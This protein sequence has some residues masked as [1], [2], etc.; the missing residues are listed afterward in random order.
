MPRLEHIGSQS[1]AGLA[2][3]RLQFRDGSDTDR[4]RQEV[5]NRLATISQPLPRDVVPQLHPVTAADPLLCYTLRA[6]RGNDGKSVYTPS[7]LRALQD[8][9]IEREFRRVPRVA[10]VRSAGGAVRR[11]E[12]QL[13]PDRLRR[14]GIT[15][16]QLQ[17]AIV[18]ANANTPGGTYVEQGRVALN[19]R[20]VGLFGGGTDPVL[21]VLG[22]QDPRQAAAKLRA[23]EQRRVRQIRSLV[24][25]AV[26]RVEVCVE[27]VVEGG[28]L[29]PGQDDSQQG[30]VVGRRPP[31]G[32][33][34]RGR[35]AGPDDEDVVQGVLLLRAGEDAQQALRAVRGRIEELNAVSGRLLPGVRIEPYYERAPASAGREDV[36]WLRGAGPVNVTRERASEQMRMV[37]ELL[38]RRPEVREVVTGVGRESADTAAVGFDQV[39]ALVLLRPAKEWPAATGKG[40]PVTWQELAADMVAE[41]M[42]KVEGVDWD[43]SADYPD[44]VRRTFTAGPGEGLLKIYGRDL[45]GLER[46]A[47]KAAVA[48]TATDDVYGVQVV[49]TMGRSSLEFCV[50]HDKCKRWGVS[51]ADVLN[52]IQAAAEGTRVTQ[53]VEGE[54]TFDVTIR[55][56][57]HL[58]GS[59]EAILDVPMDVPA[60]QAAP[61]TPVPRLLLR[62]LVSPL[63][64]D[65]H[66]DPKGSFLRQ[67]AAAIYREDGRRFIAVRFR[68]PGKDAAQT[69]ATARKK[70]APLFEAPYRARWEGGS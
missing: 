51:V 4:A 33:V 7:D 31:G 32:P 44:D 53:M 67:G 62:D 43:A 14:Y 46:L 56:P 2:C 17:T 65:G 13:D 5:I 3:L 24:I 20:G 49:H 35:A 9:I 6:P 55:L 48:L 28:R 8:W 61:A 66:P 69:L 52:V 58:R 64:D 10:D 29:A 57:K 19:V 22:L 68:L 37:R 59:E 26:N 25:T 34:G 39:Q 70:L 16:Q 18:E 11:Y 50:D 21:Q 45:E 27:D 23:E 60:G 40:R 47:G 12:I 54:K 41:L 63:G 38:L 36:V 15:L 42:L 1:F 30:V